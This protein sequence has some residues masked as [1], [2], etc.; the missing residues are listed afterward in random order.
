[1]RLLQALIR[2]HPL[3]NVA[4]V[5]VL[6]LGALAYVSMP[7]AQDPEINFNWVAVTTVL[8]GA[9]A[10]DVERLC[11]MFAHARPRRTVRGMPSVRAGGA[12]AALRAVLRRVRRAGFD[13]AAVV[14]LAPAGLP[15]RVA[16]VLVPGFRVSELL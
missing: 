1:M 8:P 3:A 15:L 9:S 4:F 2:N 11:A 12:P 5:V 16:K 7:R 14:D 10:E 13:R 6:V